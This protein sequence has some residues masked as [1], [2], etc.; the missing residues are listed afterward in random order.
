M[1]K[2][3]TK[4]GVEKP[5]KVFALITKRGR[6][7]RR[8][9]C[10]DCFKAYQAEWEL[11]HK[12]WRRG[13]ECSHKEERNRMHRA[14]YYRNHEAAKEKQKVAHRLAYPRYKLIQKAYRQKHKE[15][16]QALHAAWRKAHPEIWRAKAKTCRAKR[17][18]LIAATG[19]EAVPSYLLALQ[20]KAEEYGKCWVCGSQT[21]NFHL[22]HALP[23]IRKGAHTQDNLHYICPTCNLKKGRQTLEEFCGKSLADCPYL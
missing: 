3:C 21:K 22:D 1:N 2:V 9:K 4:C 8:T 19:N 7:Y 6:P 13:W 11:E 20:K 17:K 15:H 16:Y 12:Q 10:R 14:W 5:E 23:L 18:M